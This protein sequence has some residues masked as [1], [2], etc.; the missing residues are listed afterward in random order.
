[1]L[2]PVR[3]LALVEALS[4]VNRAGAEPLASAAGVAEAR[5][6]GWAVDLPAPMAG[7][8]VTVEPRAG[9]VASVTA[10]VILA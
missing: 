3:R 10:N 7:E 5:P 4:A 8:S 9:T 6:L 2:N 1:M